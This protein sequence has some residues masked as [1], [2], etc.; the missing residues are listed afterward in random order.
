[1]INNLKKTISNVPSKVLNENLQNGN[2]LPPI[3][4][5]NKQKNIMR[6]KIII[7]KITLNEKKISSFNLI[8][9]KKRINALGKVTKYNYNNYFNKNYSLLFAPRNKELKYYYHKK[10]RNDINKLITKKYIKSQSTGMIHNINKKIETNVFNSSRMVKDKMIKKIKS[11]RLSTLQKVNKSADNNEINQKDSKN[12]IK[13]ISDLKMFDKEQLKKNTSDLMNDIKNFI[14][15]RKNERDYLHKLINN[16][17]YDIKNENKKYKKIRKIKYS[18]ITEKQMKSFLKEKKI[19]NETLE[20]VTNE[21]NYVK[22]YLEPK[23]IKKEEEYEDRELRKKKIKE[24]RINNDVKIKF[25]YKPKNK[26]NTV[27]EN[28]IN[29]IKQ[30]FSNENN[31][32]ITINELELK[33]SFRSQL[34]LSIANP[35]EQLFNTRLYCNLID[36]KDFLKE[37]HNNENINIK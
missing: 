37:L 13:I 22:S 3:I 18:P 24:R 5:V 33:N 20:L 6:N 9:G 19:N 23:L 7:P 31:K 11:S 2:N 35:Y 21:S 27:V 15:N 8:E 10:N 26:N 28:Q 1:M 36:D 14:E 12:K 25:L 16:P 30:K 32:N 34:F 4:K 29:L 17:N